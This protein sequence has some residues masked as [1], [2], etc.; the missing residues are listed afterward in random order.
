MI[1]RSL[2]L[3]MLDDADGVD[4]REQWPSGKTVG[5]CVVVSLCLCVW[6]YY[7]NVMTMVFLNGGDDVAAA[8]STNMNL[9]I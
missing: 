4:E 1:V 6:P 8:E 9:P 2:L 7:R 5:I 3:M